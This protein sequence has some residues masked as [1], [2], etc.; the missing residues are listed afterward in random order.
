LMLTFFSLSLS[1]HPKQLEK[2]RRVTFSSASLPWMSLCV[3]AF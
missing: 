3:E 1:L 2:K